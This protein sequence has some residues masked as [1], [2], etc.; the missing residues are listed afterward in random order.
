MYIQY[1]L[2]TLALFSALLSLA[3]IRLAA[4]ADTIIKVELFNEKEAVEKLSND[5]ENENRR[6]A[7]RLADLENQVAS[8]GDV[9]RVIKTANREKYAT[10]VNTLESR[11]D[12]GERVIS[13]IIK[14]TNQFNL[15][16]SQLELQSEFN[17]LT[18]PTTYGEFN[19]ALKASLDGLKKKRVFPDLNEINDLKTLVPVLSNPIISTTISIATGLLSRY[20]QKARANNESFAKLT[21]ILD[22]TNNLKSEHQI[23][24]ARLRQ[25]NDKLQ[26]FRDQTKGF[27][28]QYLESINYKGGYNK[29]IQDKNMLTHDFMRQYREQFFNVLHAEKDNVGVI[30]YDTNKDDDVLFYL[31]QVKFY[32]NEY[33]NVLLEIN[34]FISMYDQFVAKQKNAQND[35]CASFYKENKEIFTRIEAQLKTVKD[36]FKIVYEEN[37][38]DKN[39]KRILFGF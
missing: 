20:N 31:E 11:Y 34:D 27:F 24:S 14:E 10:T 18:D 21:C 19:F 9:M 5:I 32:L 7:S 25:L 38:I 39:T 17:T 8:Q 33:E 37:R 36:N 3:P 16:F 28:G 4:Q 35:G 1:P 29:Y 12:A 6:L 30:T 13:H 23:V 2:I 15:S 26:A 22:Y